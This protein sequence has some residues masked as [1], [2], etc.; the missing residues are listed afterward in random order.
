[1]IPHADAPLGTFVAASLGIGRSTFTEHLAA[2]QR[3]LFGALLD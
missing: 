3:K 1:L 2:A